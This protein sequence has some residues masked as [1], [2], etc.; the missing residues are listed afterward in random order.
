MSEYNN[1]LT[2]LITSLLEQQGIVTG[3]AI[4]HQVS[5]AI[6]LSGVDINALQERMQIIESVLDGDPDTPEYDVSRNIITKIGELIH[7]MDEMEDP[8]NTGSLAHQIA[9]EAARIDALTGRLDTVEAAVADIATDLTQAQTDLGDLATE[10]GAVRTIA[11]SA[12]TKDEVTTMLSNEQTLVAAFCAGIK[13]GM[14]GTATVEGCNF[15]DDGD[16][17]L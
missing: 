17:E 12:V 4:Q 13:S 15:G 8:L 6:G 2:Q 3:Q 5:Q 16:G 1:D 9:A 14:D 7:R 11:E 10:V